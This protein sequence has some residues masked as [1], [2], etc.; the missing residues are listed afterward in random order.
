VLVLCVTALRS[1]PV[2]F[3]GPTTNQEIRMQSRYSN[4]FWHEGV[5]IFGGRMAQSETGRMRIDHLENDVA[6]A[7]LNL[8]EHGSRAILI[9]VKTQSPL[10][11]E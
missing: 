1:V 8:F 4:I 10:V 6:K 9:E 2:L 3:I 11:T 7:L 5:K